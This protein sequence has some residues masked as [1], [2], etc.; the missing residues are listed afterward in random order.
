MLC[1]YLLLG[2]YP[3]KPESSQIKKT[4][5]DTSLHK[6]LFFY[7]I[8][9]NNNVMYGNTA[10]NVCFLFKNCNA[11]VLL[12]WLPDYQHSFDIFLKNY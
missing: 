7:L 8:R 6:T 2:I 12:V 11:K 5:C 4:Q 10:I 1:V 3:L 9:S